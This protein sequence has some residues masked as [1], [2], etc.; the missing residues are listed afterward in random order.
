MLLSGVALGGLT[1]FA[2]QPAQAIEVTG[3][4]F[5][6]CSSRACTVPFTEEVVI[7]VAGDSP[8]QGTFIW[9]D[10]GVSQVIVNNGTASTFD[11]THSYTVAG[12]YTLAIQIQDALSSV[13]KNSYKVSA[14]KVG[15]FG[16]MSVST[17]IE[18]Y[19]IVN[20][21][22]R[23][24]LD[25]E[26]ITAILQNTGSAYLQPWTVTFYASTWANQCGQKSVSQGLLPG[27]YAYL[28]I[29]TLDLL[30]GN[31]SPVW[32]KVTST[33]WPALNSTSPSMTITW[34]TTATPNAGFILRSTV[35][36]ITMATGG[37]AIL[38]YQIVNTGQFT[39]DFTGSVSMSPQN[40][41]LVFPTD[42][43]NP[44]HSLTVNASAQ[45]VS[46]GGVG[47]YQGVGRIILQPGQS[48][49]VNRTVQALSSVSSNSIT[50]TDRVQ[51]SCLLPPTANG[52][53]SPFG[54]GNLVGNTGLTNGVQ[55]QS[56]S[57]S[58]SLSIAGSS[59]AMSAAIP[60]GNGTEQF[61]GTVIT[62]GSNIPFL[63]V[64]FVFWKTAVPGTQFTLQAGTV[65]APGTVTATATGLA[66][67]TNYTV[68]FAAQSTG[69]AIFSNQVGFVTAGGCTGTG[70]A[71]PGG[72]P[73]STP[74]NFV[75]GF[76]F[77]LSAASGIPAEIFGFFLGL[78]LIGVFLMA[79]L[80]IPAYLGVKDLEVP[81]LVWAALIPTLVIVNVLFFLWPSWV[82]IL[83][84]VP[85]AVLLASYFLRGG[86]A[87]ANG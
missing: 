34:S 45:Q 55:P 87:G 80:I 5:L 33:S 1:L 9:G 76:L 6:Q 71:G 21:L 56:I 50:L 44:W 24:R 17:R 59:I 26:T 85:E 51:G 52:L 84:V 81:E 61:Q 47:L 79:V 42:L 12:N 23:E 46:F 38:Q 77:F 82:L 14:W 53:D 3:V 32:A 37:F 65:Y 75:Q 72:S 19:G 83:V 11:V 4:Q 58:V 67:N 68:Q 41:M 70:C 48:I 43:G 35:P 78:V 66:P 73:G 57:V 36:S 63:N 7:N 54:C 16:Q 62:L 64:W 10:G 27:D 15:F 20:A 30:C 13:W 86:E 8:F 18:G 31:L 22:Q 2:S 28:T 25:S 60:L 69:P 29:D 74:G 39:L 40:T 49:F